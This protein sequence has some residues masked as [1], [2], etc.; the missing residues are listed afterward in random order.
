MRTKNQNQDTAVQADQELVK[1]K[2]KKRKR[3]LP[4]LIRIPIRLLV[5]I[6][7]CNFAVSFIRLGS[8]ISEFVYDYLN[9]PT[10]FPLDTESF[11][12]ELKNTSSDIDGLTRYEKKQM[13]LSWRDG[14]DTDHD[15]LTDKEEIEVYHSD[16][17]KSSTAGDLYTDGYKVEH[18][19]DLFATYPYDQEITFP[20]NSCSEIILE[21]NCPEDLYANIDDI[22]DNA[23]YIGYTTLKAYEIHGYSGK[24]KIDLAQIFTDKQPKNLKF[25]VVP[26]GSDTGKTTSV[27][28]TDGVANLN[29]TFQKEYEY[30]VYLATGNRISAFINKVSYYMDI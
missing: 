17:L 30:A 15:G 10:G 6:L 1:V 14:S 19:M 7:V 3:K 9:R 5:I 13:G 21:A 22:T 18:N 20:Y 4:L 8:G 28:I 16:P 11:E 25:L 12:E 23:T 26:L 24:L 27:K 29:Y 2:R